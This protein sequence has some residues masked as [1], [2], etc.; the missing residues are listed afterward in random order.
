[1]NHGEINQVRVEGTV[2]PGFE[3][4]REKFEQDMATLLEKNAQLCVYVGGEK[5][6]D[7]WGSAAGDE[8]FSADSLV[9]VF[10]SG[11]SLEAIAIA[12]LV[13]KGLLSYDDKIARC[14]P[15]FAAR[16]KQDLTVADLMRHEAGLAWLDTSI[17]P[18]DLLSHNIRQN[19][20]GSVIEGQEA[21]F[22]EVGTAREYHAITRGWIANE[23][24]RRVDPQGRTIGEHLKEDL[25]MPLAAD[26][27]IG[28]HEDCLCRVSPVV[29]IAPGKHLLES[30]KPKFMGRKVR[31]NLFQISGKLVR[32]VPGFR[33]RTRKGA[34]RPFTGM[35]RIEFFN[36]P[37]VAMG[38]TPSANAHASA[39]GLAKLAAVMAGGGSWQGREY[40]SESAW[41]LMHGEP[42]LR[43]MGMP[44]TFTQ[45]G[46]ALF[47]E[48][49]PGAPRIERA[50]NQGREGFY[51]WMGLGGSVFQWH[52]EHRI[53]FAYVPTSLHLLDLVNERAKVFQQKVLSLI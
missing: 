16:G 48:T 34:P 13:S 23:L 5:V 17:P 4:V 20:V 42:V 53:G 30:M 36:K 46:V 9:N 37:E 40:V 28:V 29:P 3:S 33:H 26:V 24:F 21:Q 39:R 27:H 2:A 15:E 11:K 19:R 45:G 41:A 10:S 51:G 44:T 35:D 31:D 52:P 6:V 32:L 12:S 43:S 50:L 22:R 8:D 38:E 1:M 49:S 47:S 7:L 25:Q 14:W 18:E